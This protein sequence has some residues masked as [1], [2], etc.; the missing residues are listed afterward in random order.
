MAKI[1]TADYDIDLE[2]PSLNNMTD[3]EF[4]EFCVQNKNTRIERDNHKQIYIMAPVGNLSSSQNFE[5][6]GQLFLWNKNSKLG[7]AFDSSAGFYLS[8]TSMLSPDAAWISNQ[9][10]KNVSTD[11]KKK[12]AYI[13]PDF[14]IELMSPSDRL[15]NAKQKMEKWITNGVLLAWLINPANETVFIYKQNKPTE[16]I[17]G[18]NNKISRE[19]I[20][21]GFELNLSVLKD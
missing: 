14:I 12:F 7:I 21:P 20:L 11:E 15:N 4:F 13:A 6:S 5:I 8:D 19:D 18:F 2:V 17:K 3:D 1:V 16:Q 9:K 10:W